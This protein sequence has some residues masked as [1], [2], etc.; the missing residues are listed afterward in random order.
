MSVICP[1]RDE[2]VLA[3]FNDSY[4]PATHR[5]GEAVAPTERM[6]YRPIADYA[7]IGDCRSAAL[8]S[9]DG[10][11][12][13]LCFPRFDSASVFAA[14]LDAERGGRF[15]VAPRDDFTVTRR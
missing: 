12:D 10:S 4:S 15:R 3:D 5:T 6:S 13:W 1:R 11:I 2:N 8:V 14:L 7:I 9:R